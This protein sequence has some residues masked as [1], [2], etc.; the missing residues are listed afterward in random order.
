M[1]F[2]AGKQRTA[3][4]IARSPVTALKVRASL[5]ERASLNCQLRFHKVFLSTLVE[6]L[7]HTSERVS[8]ASA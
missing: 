7:S 5:I 8:A 6:R 4:I 2:I 3:S 1:G